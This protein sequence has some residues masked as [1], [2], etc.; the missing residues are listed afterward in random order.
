MMTNIDSALQSVKEVV[1]MINLWQQGL[2]IAMFCID[3]K[4][5]ENVKNT[6]YE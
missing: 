4:D 6:K 3:A 1:K 5:W 2:K